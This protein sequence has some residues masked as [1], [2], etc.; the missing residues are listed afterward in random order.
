MIERYEGYGRSV[1]L[2]AERGPYP[3]HAY[4]VPE[5]FNSELWRWGNAGMV[6]GPGGDRRNALEGGYAL[7]DWTRFGHVSDQHALGLYFCRY[8]NR[9]KATVD[10]RRA[11][12]ANCHAGTD[13]PSL[14]EIHLDRLHEGYTGTLPASMHFFVDGNEHAYDSFA[15][16]YGL[17]SC[18]L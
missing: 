1:V 18:I 9:R 15:S 4:D 16:L 8:R 10:Y 12:V 14:Y 2:G 6:I 13:D 3:T 11:L 5:D 17:R 7:E